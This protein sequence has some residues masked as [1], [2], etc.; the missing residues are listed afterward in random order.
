MGYSFAAVQHKVRVLG[1]EK[2][3]RWTEKEVKFLKKHYPHYTNHQIALRMGRSE[4]TV[5]LKAKQLGLR[6]TRAHLIFIGTAK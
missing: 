3:K 1:L 6:K 5:K 2:L 4:P